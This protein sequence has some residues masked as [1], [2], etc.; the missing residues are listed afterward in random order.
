KFA[1]TTLLG[2]VLF[3]GFIALF[4]LLT[5]GNT[6]TEDTLL[7]TILSGILVGTGIGLV[8]R[9]GSSTG[10]FDILSLLFHK[11]FHI[12]VS[13][14]M[15]LI[16]IVI[17]AMQCFIMPLESILYGI[18]NVFLYSVLIDRVSVIGQKRIQVKIVSLYHEEIRHLILHHL[19]R[20]ATILYGETGYLREDCHVVLTV[21]SPRE[22]TP[23]MNAVQKIDKEAFIIISEVSEVRG[24]GFTTEKIRVH[25]EYKP[26]PALLES[27]DDPSE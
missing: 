22:L 16:D 19:N 9:V 3:P 18:L 1:L 2:T 21:I 23:L 4:Q 10:G 8:I 20:G 26:D 12:P 6:I 11:W 13:V 14:A 7:A 25:Q 24:R 27:F 5:Q 17:V 15:W